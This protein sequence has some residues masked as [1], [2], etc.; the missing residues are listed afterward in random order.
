MKGIV[1]FCLLASTAALTITIPTLE[2][3]KG[4]IEPQMLF[5]KCFGGSSASDADPIS[6]L[7]KDK[8]PTPINLDASCRDFMDVGRAVIGGRNERYNPS[9][10]TCL[11]GIRR[12]ALVDAGKAVEEVS[13][14]RSGYLP[15]DVKVCTTTTVTAAFYLTYAPDTNTFMILNSAKASWFFTTELTG[16]DIFVATNPSLG[17]TFRNKP[18]IIHGNA[19]GLVNTK[20][21]K[22]KAKGDGADE[23]MT[24]NGGYNLVAR[25][26]SAGPG[27][28]L[29]SYATNHPGIRLCTYNNAG[30]TPQVYYFIGHY[31]VTRGVGAW[32]FFLKGKTNGKITKIDDCKNKPG[33]VL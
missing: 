10:N 11:M 8:K 19:N 13:L 23:I 27:T 30:S 16:C 12:T 2:R 15:V 32:V 4:S 14:Y 26:Y 21:A 9:E 24:A 25:V 6:N 28:D 3:H 22:L 20:A 17:P 29:G 7:R 5:P 1:L 18:L 33:I 31:E